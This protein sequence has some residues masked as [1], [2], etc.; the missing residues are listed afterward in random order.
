MFLGA[1][2]VFSTVSDYGDYGYWWRDVGGDGDI[3]RFLC[4]CDAGYL[5]RK[6]APTL[7]RDDDA[8]VRAIKDCILDLRRQEVL[9]KEQARAEWTLVEGFESPDVWYHETELHRVTAVAELSRNRHNP[10]AVSF[11]EKVM[12]RLREVLQAEM[13]AEQ[14]TATAPEKG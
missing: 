1:D 2:G 4:D 8:T 10:Q 14:Q 9:T 11:V 5:V 12:P 6:L 7:E 13:A 3:R